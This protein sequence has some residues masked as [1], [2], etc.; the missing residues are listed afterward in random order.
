MSAWQTALAPAELRRRSNDEDD[1]DDGF[2]FLDE[3]GEEEL[4]D[5]LD[6]EE[7]LEDDELDLGGDRFEFIEDDDQ[8]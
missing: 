6:D 1:F 2:S 4:D 3:D 5:E 7:S 8:Y